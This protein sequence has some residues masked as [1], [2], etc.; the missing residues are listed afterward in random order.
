MTI[1]FI[2]LEFLSLAI[3]TR[4]DNEFCCHDGKTSI[5]QEKVGK[6]KNTEWWLLCYVPMMYL[7][8]DDSCCL[9]LRSCYL[10]KSVHP[11]MCVRIWDQTPPRLT[12]S[13]L[14]DMSHPSYISHIPCSNWFKL[15]TKWPNFTNHISHKIFFSGVQ[16]NGR[17]PSQRNWTRWWGWG[18]LPGRY[19]DPLALLG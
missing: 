10:D 4:G 12:S 9:C 13:T 1:P 6:G 2:L 3:L 15:Q 7:K 17:L 5:T 8:V 16:W 18:D 14:V 19:I 11:L